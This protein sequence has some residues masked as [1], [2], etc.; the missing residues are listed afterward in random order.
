MA[1]LKEAKVCVICE[2]SDVEGA[3]VSRVIAS[4]KFVCA[5]CLF[6]LSK[7]FFEQITGEWIGDDNNIF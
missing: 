3:M 2:E 5:K 4:E 7:S 6:C 1:V